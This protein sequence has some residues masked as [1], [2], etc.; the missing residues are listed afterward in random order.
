MFVSGI[1][2]GFAYYGTVFV[3]CQNIEHKKEIGSRLDG[4]INLKLLRI[5]AAAD[6]KKNWLEAVQ[7]T[8]F[9]VQTHSL[10]NIGNSNDLEGMLELASTVPKIIEDKSKKEWILKAILKDYNLIGL[11]TGDAFGDITRRRTQIFQMCANH[12]SQALLQL[13]TI[14]TAL[15]HPNKYSEKDIK[16]LA[17]A[18][19]KLDAFIIEIKNIYSV[20]SGYK[21]QSRY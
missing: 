9:H 6:F 3:E 1:I 10:G 19:K 18:K 7:N 14:D 20:F 15:D 13:R 16:R 8:H 17:R 12:Y 11:Q 4:K 2:T 5:E 21:I